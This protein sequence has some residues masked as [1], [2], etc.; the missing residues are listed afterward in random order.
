MG[1]FSQSETAH[2]LDFGHEIFHR[3][4]PPSASWDQLRVKP[5]KSLYHR[6]RASEW[7]ENE[8]GRRVRTQKGAKKILAAPSGAATVQIY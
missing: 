5:P 7:A 1:D 2:P 8:R 4:I 6:S 3:L